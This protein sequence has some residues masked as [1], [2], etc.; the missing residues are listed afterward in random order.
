LPVA[1]VA[2]HASNFSLLA[3]QI[4]GATSIRRRILTLAN[5][6]AHQGLL[7]CSRY[8]RR[9]SIHADLPG[10]KIDCQCT[11]GRDA[12]RPAQPR[13]GPRLRVGWS[14][15]LIQRWA[16]ALLRGF[17]LSPSRLSAHR[18]EYHQTI[19]SCH[20]SSGIGTDPRGWV[21][22]RRRCGRHQRP[23]RWS[24]R[25]GWCR[26]RLRSRSPHGCEEAVRVC[27]CRRTTTCRSSQRAIR[28]LMQG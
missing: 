6:L 4:F 26:S 7:S 25:C 3:Q 17:V 27:R 20:A 16:C 19:P 12:S 1:R 2:R 9:S 28:S 13:R 24:S 21:P 14:L 15:T 10:G 22:E 23:L 11:S 5:A 18:H 8:G